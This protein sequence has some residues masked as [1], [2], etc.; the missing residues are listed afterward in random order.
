MT[1]QTGAPWRRG[2]EP[3]RSQLDALPEDQSEF[4][5]GSVA[6]ELRSEIERRADV[7]RDLMSAAIDHGRELSEQARDQVRRSVDRSRDAVVERPLSS[8]T[9]AAIGGL[10]IGMLLSRRS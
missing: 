5:M 8:I 10:L 7:T 9:L 3:H 1:L 6:S 2:K 4:P